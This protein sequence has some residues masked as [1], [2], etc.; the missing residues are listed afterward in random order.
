MRIPC[1]D[2]LPQSSLLFVPRLVVHR[3]PSV[4]CRQR[5]PLS[6]QLNLL[7]QITTTGRQTRDAHLFHLLTTGAAAESAAAAAAAQGLLFES[8]AFLSCVS[9]LLSSLSLSFLLPLSSSL[10]LSSPFVFSAFLPD[11][12]VTHACPLLQRHE[13]WWRIRR[14][15]FVHVIPHSALFAVSVHCYKRREGTAFQ[16][17]ESNPQTIDE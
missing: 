2:S 7:Q 13:R 17:V 8:V 9:R 4:Q 12:R 1:G 6:S 15:K 5:L 10:L 3:V 11:S 14:R 16:L